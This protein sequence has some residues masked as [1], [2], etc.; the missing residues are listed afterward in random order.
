MWARA[1]AGDAPAPL[2]AEVAESTCI[3]LSAD[4]MVDEI[5]RAPQV[6]TRCA[7]GTAAGFR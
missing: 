3:A 4:A 5:D 7:N 2:A 1:V 6:G